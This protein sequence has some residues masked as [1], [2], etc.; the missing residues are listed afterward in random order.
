VTV[1]TSV[2]GMLL[3][4]VTL[5]AGIVIGVAY[6]RNRTSAHA[7]RGAGSNHVMHRL[8]HDLGLDS[9]QHEAITA[10]LNRRQRTV[11]STWHAMKPHVHATLDSTLREIAGVLRPEQMRK[12]RRMV[13]AMHPAMLR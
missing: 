2:K 10:I 6:E 12:Y 11:D 7:V 1:P 3:L 8:K 13:E 4:A 9:A 5:S